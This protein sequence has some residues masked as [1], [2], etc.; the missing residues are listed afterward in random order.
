MIVCVGEQMMTNN[1]EN[2]PETELLIA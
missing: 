2:M 1:Y